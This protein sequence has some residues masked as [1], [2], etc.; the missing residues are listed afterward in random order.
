MK[1][2]MRL[3]AGAALLLALGPAPA[4]AAAA[5]TPKGKVVVALGSDPRT[6]DPHLP[7]TR[8]GIIADWPLFDDLLGRDLK[9]MKPVPRL[10][11]SVKPMDELT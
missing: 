1:R 7:T 3:A 11:E 8:M 4:G 5:V 10:A 2:S 6:L 9:T